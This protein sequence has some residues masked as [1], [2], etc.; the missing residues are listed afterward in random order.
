MVARKLQHSRLL[1][2]GTK[3]ISSASWGGLSAAL[4]SMAI[5]RMDR[6]VLAVSIATIWSYDRESNLTLTPNLGS[7]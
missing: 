2:S 3:E 6:R 4:K 1:V 7:V 5:G